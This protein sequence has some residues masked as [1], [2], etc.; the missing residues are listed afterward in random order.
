MTHMEFLNVISDLVYMLFLFGQEHSEGLHHLL[1][2]TPI[3]TVHNTANQ[4][5]EYSYIG[6]MNRLVDRGQRSP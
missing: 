5:T 3:C 1:C 4:Q 6:H 2:Y